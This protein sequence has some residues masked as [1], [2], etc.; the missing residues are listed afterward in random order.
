MVV[1]GV[2]DFTLL[3]IEERLELIVRVEEV[4]VF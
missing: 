3:L 1:G 2:H 4:E